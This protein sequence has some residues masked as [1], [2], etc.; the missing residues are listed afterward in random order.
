MSSSRKPDPRQLS[1]LRGVAEAGG[2]VEAA[3]DPEACEECMLWGWLEPRGAHGFQLTQGG[4]TELGLDSPTAEHRLHPRVKAMRAGVIVH[5]A[6]GRS[7]ECRILD[8]SMGGARVH[9]YAPDIPRE[10]LTLID[11]ELGVTHQLRIAWSLGPLM[12]VAF[13]STDE[14][15]G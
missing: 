3:D 1:A 7:F 4:R 12:D 2:L 14:L 5:G 11:Q 8:V 15:R 13:R 9:L 10:D 6:S